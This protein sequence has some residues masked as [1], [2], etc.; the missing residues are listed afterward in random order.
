MKTFVR[1]ITA[2][3]AIA[4]VSIGMASAQQRGRGGNNGGSRPAATHQSAPKASASHQSAAP[5]QSASAPSHQASASRPAAPQR[6]VSRPVQNT[7]H[8]HHGGNVKYNGSAH[9][10]HVHHDV[11]HDHHAPVHHDA[12]HHHA[13]VHHDVHH[14]A[15][16]HHHHHAPA[17]LHYHAHPVYHRAL[18][19]AYLPF[20]VGDVTYYYAGGTYYVYDPVYG[21]EVVGCPTN[22][23]LPYLPAGSRMVTYRGTLYYEYDGMWMLPVEG[24]YMIV[25]RPVSR[26][27]ISIPMPSF[28]FYARF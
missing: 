1:K 23:F 2:L 17:H 26:V 20:Y 3:L 21:Y 11:H 22:V 27:S 24:Q 9:N 16:V 4:I 12:H 6:N 19:A 18:P 28:R 14:H 7:Q 5:R 8:S 25:E 15:P 13:P 10:A